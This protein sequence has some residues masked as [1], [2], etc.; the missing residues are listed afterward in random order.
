MLFFFNLPCIDAVAGRGDLEQRL[1]DC[2]REA[3]RLKQER[4][5]ALENARGGK[6]RADEL[7]EQLRAQ[8]EAEMAAAGQ[9]RSC[10]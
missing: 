2:E 5:R 7:A 3:E 6:D 4:D 1:A 8:H 9:V 10:I